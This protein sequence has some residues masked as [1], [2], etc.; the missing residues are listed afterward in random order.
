MIFCNNLWGKESLK[1]IYV[2]TYH[3]AVHVKPKH[4]KSTTFEKNKYV[5]WKIKKTESW[6]LELQF[7]V[8]SIGTLVFKIY[9]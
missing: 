6:V 3:F 5:N 8:F 7:L 1:N 2:Y 4:Y 9:V